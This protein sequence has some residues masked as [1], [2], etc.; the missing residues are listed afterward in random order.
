[1]DF[2]NFN[3]SNQLIFALIVLFVLLAYWTFNFIV[4][5][6]LARFG[7]GTEPK[8]FAVIFFLGSVV[9]FFVNVLLFANL[10]FAS[11]KHQL[12]ELS[13]SSF[14]ITYQK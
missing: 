1:M 8:K 5:Y 6:H 10:D 12:I 9:L 2:L 4:I 13:N 11:I 3:I 7:I 14:N